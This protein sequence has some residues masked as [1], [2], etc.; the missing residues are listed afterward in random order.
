MY[1]CMLRACHIAPLCA[2]CTSAHEPIECAWLAAAQL[3]PNLL[4][5]HFDLITP[6]RCVM[7]ATDAA[8]ALE[9]NAFWR[10]QSH[11]TERRDTGIWRLH[12]HQVVA[13]MLSRCAHL[14]TGDRCTEEFVQRCCGILDVNAMEVRTQRSQEIPV[15]GLYPMASLLPHDCANNTFITVDAAKVMRVYASVAI[16]AGETVYNNYTSSLLVRRQINSYLS[17]R[18]KLVDFRKGHRQPWRTSVAGQV[19]PLP[20]QPLSRSHRTGH[21][22]QFGGLHKLLDHHHRV[23]NVRRRRTHMDV[24]RLPGDELRSKRSTASGRSQTN[25]RPSGRARRCGRIGTADRSP[26]G[27]AEWQ[28]LFGGGVEAEAGRIAAQYVRR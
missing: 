14:L 25:G 17:I 26:I 10:L 13:P 3:P 2:L 27:S 4:L 22:L 28:S 8:R 24:H 20:V 16:A 15:R 9:F 12:R 6:L 18:L 5:D 23:A 7:L 21:A 11:C 19:F 1:I